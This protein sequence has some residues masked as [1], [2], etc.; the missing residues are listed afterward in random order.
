MKHAYSALCLAAGMALAPL[1]LADGYMQIEDIEGDSSRVRHEGWIVI[2]SMTEG[3][4][5]PTAAG[6]GA[7]RARANAV[8][9]GVVVIKEFD[10]SSPLLRKALV[11]GQRF[12]EIV[13]DFATGGQSSNVGMK[14]TLT[15]ALITKIESNPGGSPATEEVAFAYQKIE[16]TYTNASGQT[17]TG[18]YDFGA[19]R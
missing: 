8:T 4:K 10:K 6:A 17:T 16:W 3:Y 15:N 18:S 9:E 13:I 14:Y 2:E 11:T 19:G 1:A 7:G 5:I 12:P